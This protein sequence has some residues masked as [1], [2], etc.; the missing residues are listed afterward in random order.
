MRLLASY[1][2]EVLVQGFAVWKRTDEV[3]NPIKILAET[4]IGLAAFVLAV[5]A[6]NWVA[7]GYTKPDWGPLLA[8]AGAFWL[9]WCFLLAGPFRAWKVQKQSSDNY[10]KRLERR[11][12]VH[13]PRIH[14]AKTS[15]GHYRHYVQVRVSC[16]GSSAIEECRAHF[17]GVEINKGLPDEVIYEDSGFYL[18]ALVDAS[19]ITLQPGAPHYLNIAFARKLDPVRRM[20]P[21]EPVLELT[22]LALT[23]LLFT[24]GRFCFKVVLSGR[25]CAPY[26]FGVDVDTSDSDGI[27]V[28][29]AVTTAPT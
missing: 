22:P 23:P 8:L 19:V 25:D 17:V 3:G 11:F 16:V 13:P 18:W 15:D 29:I 24:P 27:N 9:I 10:A 14:E 7:T 12:V 2:R 20:R 26:A 1:I 6:V 28:A 5:F 4:L 21:V